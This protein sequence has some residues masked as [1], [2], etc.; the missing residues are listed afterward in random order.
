MNLSQKRFYDKR[1]SHT[2]RALNKLHNSLVLFY[3][4]R[5]IRI[6]LEALGVRSVSNMLEVG[7]GQGTDAI[8][9]SRYANHTLA[10]DISPEALK[11]A[12]ILSRLKT[13]HERLSFIV[14]DADYLPLREDVFDIVF[15]K[16]LLHHV[17]DPMITLSEM[18]RVARISGKVLSIEAN[19]YNPQMRVIGLIY[20]SVDKGVFKSTKERLITFFK[21]AG[22]SE[23]K[24]NEVEFLP[25][26]ILFE[27]R[28]PLCTE[29]F[30]ESRY[31]LTVITKI[32]DFMQTFSIMKKFAN[33][34]IIYG[35]KKTTL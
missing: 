30:T 3:D 1:F 33:Y 24:T 29:Y 13:C 11:I 21:R 20:F 18:K 14:G 31:I 26:H 10:I 17:C 27:Y 35:V 16:D 8:L 7:C 5:L 2:N 28:S 23:I 6:V 25:R 9:F 22:L 32:E 19:A 34:H 15:C 12:N 4:T